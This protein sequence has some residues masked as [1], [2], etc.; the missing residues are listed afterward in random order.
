MSDTQQDNGW[1]L[2]MD[3]K[4]YPPAAPAQPAERRFPA[5]LIVCLG[6]GVVALVI[7]AILWVTPVS[8]YGTDC[9]SYIARKSFSD[10]TFGG[11]YAN[12]VCGQA[13]DERRNLMLLFAIGGILVA[14]IGISTEVRFRKGDADSNRTALS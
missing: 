7:A 5:A 8:D 3:G 10:V 6:L 14:G 2:G 13:L 4:W 11:A 9:G 1:W 12:I